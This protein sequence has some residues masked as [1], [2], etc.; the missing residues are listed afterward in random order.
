[1]NNSNLKRRVMIRVYVE[2]V[3]DA[4]MRYPDY[5]MFLLFVITSLMLVSMHDVFNNIPKN[6]LSSAFNFFLV[7]LRETSLIIQIL[8]AGF[9]VRTIVASIMLAYKNIGSSKWFLT[10]LARIKY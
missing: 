2:Y 1:M 6:N 4:F 9:F 10:K 7:A 3:K 8:I 5:F